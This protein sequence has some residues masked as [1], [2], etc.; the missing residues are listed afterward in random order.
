MKNIAEI[1][2][3]RRA[4][5]QSLLQT[6]EWRRFAFLRKEAAG[7]ACE[8]C[9]RAG[10]GI[11]LNVHHHAYEPERLPWEYAPAEVAVLCSG[12]HRE[13]HECLQAFRRHVFRHLEPQSFRVLNGALAVGLEHYDGLRL[14]HSI[15]SLVGTPGAVQRFAMG[16][17]LTAK[18]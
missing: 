7:F 8:I 5:Y 12:C 16:L 13:M 18:P 11:E 1:M 9:R 17:D 4:R 6:L 15:A 10:P 14:C 2:D 3:V